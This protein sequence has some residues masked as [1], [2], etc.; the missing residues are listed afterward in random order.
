MTALH[1][2]STG[3][4]VTAPLARRRAAASTTLRSVTT[5]SPTPSISISR[6]GGAASVS[7]KVPKRRISSF[8][9]GFTSRRGIERN[10]TISRSS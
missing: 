9:I 5:L 6:A 2:D 7:A 10:S 3:R 8:A 1:D 4:F